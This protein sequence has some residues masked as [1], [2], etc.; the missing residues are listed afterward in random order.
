MAAFDIGWSV[1]DGEGTILT[2]SSDPELS[3]L[4][5]EGFEDLQIVA[6]A[7]VNGQAIE[8]DSR[9]YTVVTSTPAEVAVDVS[10]T[11]EPTQV[12]ASPT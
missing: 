8:L 10:P 6:Q 3:Y 7:N 4:V 9:S 2:T 5:E 12:V 1:R 11:L